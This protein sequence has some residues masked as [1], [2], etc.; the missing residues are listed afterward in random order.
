MQSL[1]IKQEDSSIGMVMKQKLVAKILPLS[2]L[3]LLL[4]TALV[5]V[6]TQ[7][8]Q[9]GITIDEPEEDAYGQLSLAWYNTLGKDTSFLTAFPKSSI[10]LHGAIFEVIVA[11]AQHIF[12][13]PWHMGNAA[14]IY[15]Q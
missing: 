6:F 2:L 14:E 3:G 1:R 5:I 15:H 8:D 11:E 7:A 4:V 13:Q 9:Y 10:Q 12:A